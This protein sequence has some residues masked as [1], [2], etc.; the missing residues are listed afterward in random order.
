MND[1]STVT[2]FLKLLQ[3]GAQNY[4][5]THPKITLLPENGD[6][7]TSIENLRHLYQEGLIFLALVAGKGGILFIF[8]TG[9]QFL[10]T[11]LAVGG[12]PKTEAL[13][14]IMSEFG[15]GSKEELLNFY[16][17]Q[18]YGPIRHDRPP[19]VYQAVSDQHYHSEMQLFHKLLKE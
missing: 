19:P 5:P 15:M 8:E 3:D 10:A 16:S 14:V 4:T 17:I 7:A 12:G 18:D 1:S 9:E 11:G 2:Y 13:A 6:P